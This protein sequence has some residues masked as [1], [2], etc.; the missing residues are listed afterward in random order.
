MNRLVAGAAV[1]LLTGAPL[2][3]AAAGG[4]QEQGRRIAVMVCGPCHVVAPD[5][6]FGP[7]LNEPT[8]GFGEIANRP[9]TSAATLRRFLTDTHWDDGSIPMRMPDPKLAEHQKAA[10]IAYILGLRRQP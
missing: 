7:M 2:A 5:Q 4:Q 1:L 8:P 9:G 6:E 10:V 3:A